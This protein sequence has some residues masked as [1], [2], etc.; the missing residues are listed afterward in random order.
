[1][2]HKTLLPGPGRDHALLKPLMLVML[3]FKGPWAQSL[4]MIIML[5]FGG[6]FGADRD[7]AQYPQDTTLSPVNHHRT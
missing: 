7:D 2:G 5:A 3:A 1:M 4:W 6:S